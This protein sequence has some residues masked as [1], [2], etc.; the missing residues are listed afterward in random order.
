MEFGRVFPCLH[1]SHFKTNSFHLTL[2]T[3]A[4]EV[5]VGALPPSYGDLLPLQPFISHRSL[6]RG[7]KESCLKIHLDSASVQKL[8]KVGAKAGLNMQFL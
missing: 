4:N 6:T 3:D 1:V 2:C 5:A 7:Q 8:V